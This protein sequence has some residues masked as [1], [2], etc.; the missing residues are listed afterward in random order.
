MYLSPVSNRYILIGT[1][2]G[3]GY[4]CKTGRYITV[5]GSS[6][7]LWNK[8]SNWVDWIRGVMEDLNEPVCKK[9]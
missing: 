5:E 1:V 8:V 2:Q 3:S 7:G 9:F 6:N 4:I